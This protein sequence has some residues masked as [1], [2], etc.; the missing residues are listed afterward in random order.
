MAGPGDS[1]PATR[2]ESVAFASDGLALEGV[3]HIPALS[4][5]PAVVICHPHPLYGGDM[6]NNVV[7]ALARAITERGI[8]VL[9][10]NFRGAGGSEGSFGG[11]A[12]ER[13]DA[14]AALTFLR[15]RPEVDPER[16]GIAGYSFGAAVALLAADADLKAV[17]AVSTPTIARDLAEI[18]LTCPVLLVVGEND[19]V[20]PPT[21]LAGL[22][23]YI[24]PRAEMIMIPG[25]DHFW[26]GDEAE[27]ATMVADFFARMLAAP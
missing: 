8:A 24:G 26:S 18:R 15:Q 9:R 21:R 2:S 7:V 10:F 25:A 17:V 4:P 23:A 11:G 27:L 19:E 3:L 13:A 1:R 5:S 12:G 6:H 16:M 20:A 22:D 14:R